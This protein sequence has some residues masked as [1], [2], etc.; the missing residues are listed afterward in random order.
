MKRNYQDCGKLCFLDKV[1]STSS[2]LE[3]DDVLRAAKT[4]FQLCEVIGKVC[5]V[6]TAVTSI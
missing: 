4:L 5:F 6:S 1:L 2:E 3:K